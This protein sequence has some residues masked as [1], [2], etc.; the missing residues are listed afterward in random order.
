MKRLILLVVLVCYSI[1]GY[2][3]G[4]WS[5]F[6]RGVY[7]QFWTYVKCNNGPQGT[8]QK[9]IFHCGTKEN[10]SYILLEFPKR[11]LPQD[12]DVFVVELENSKE[13]R[14][15]IA[16]E[17]LVSKNRRYAWQIPGTQ[18]QT[19]LTPRS[20]Y[21]IRDSKKYDYHMGKGLKKGIAMWAKNSKECTDTPFA[22]VFP[23]PAYPSW[24]D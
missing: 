6:F 15:T 2:C 8:R 20:I 16:P 5:N 22:I 18:A 23:Q 24:R 11:Y 12:G 3:G 4:N 9:V 19:M 10:I 17:N 13:I 7:G 14:L 1:S 21:L